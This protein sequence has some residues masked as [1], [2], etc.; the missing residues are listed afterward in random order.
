MDILIITHFTSTFSATDNDRFLYLAKY[1]G[2]DNDVEIVTSD[3]CHEKKF[4]RNKVETEWPIKVTFLKEKG[5][6]RNVCLKRFYS[7]ILWGK[8]VDKYLK[9][10]KKPDVI[11]CAIPSL[12]AAHNAA[13]YCKKNKIKYIIDIQDLWPEAFEMVFNIPILKQLLFTP[14]ARY[15]DYS[16]SSANCICAVS[17]TYVKRALKVNVNCETGTTV[18]LGTD[19]SVFDRNVSTTPY[20]KH[21]DLTEIWIAYC[22]TLG[23]SYDL[24]VVFDAI[25]LLN[26]RKIH[27]IKF[28]IMGDGPKADEFADYAKRKNINAIFTG[29]LSYDVMCATLC[30]CDIAINPIVHNAA[31]SIINKHGDY[32]AAGIPVVSTQ[33]NEEYRHLIEI[34][35]MGFNCT[36]NDAYDL[37]NKIEILIND[38]DLRKEMGRN[39]RKCA[40]EK[41]DRANSY[42]SLIS[43][44]TG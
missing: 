1:L 43:A 41:F 9:K 40:E 26:G 30:E 15:A 5:Y 35:N 29:R 12:T 16:Y 25:R 22:G 27:N 13:K 44:I 36:N 20:I 42:K 4:H 2:K 37:A 24:K 33:E 11:Y 10:R 28:I 38:T 34:Y 17:E 18:F 8:E 3:F 32:A 7:H 39:A 19:L 6:P 31:Q 21:T 14:I 23:S